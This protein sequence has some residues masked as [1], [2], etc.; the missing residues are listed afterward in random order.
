MIRIVKIKMDAKGIDKMLRFD[1]DTYHLL[2]LVKPVNA[3]N[4]HLLVNKNN[5]I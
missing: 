1:I 2:H 5:Q 3:E 4:E